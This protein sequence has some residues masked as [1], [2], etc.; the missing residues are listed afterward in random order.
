VLAIPCNIR[1]FGLI[2]LLL[3]MSCGQHSAEYYGF[4]NSGE[5]TTIA[6]DSSDLAKLA[7]AIQANDLDGLN[8]LIQ[9]GIDLNQIL[10][11]GNPPVI[12]AILW[13]RV[14]IVRLLLE[15]G[16]NKECVDSA[17]VSAKELSEDASEEIYNIFHPKEDDESIE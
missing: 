1:Q 14:E 16:A 7:E 10:K 12:E 4:K 3:I 2:S 9:K 11:N 15:K 8:I 6:Q 17:G 13:E 5:A